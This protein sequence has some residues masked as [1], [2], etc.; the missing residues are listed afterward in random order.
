MLAIHRSKST[1]NSKNNRPLAPNV[2]PATIHHSGP[3]KVSKRYWSPASASADGTRTS[4]FRGRRL[5]GRTVKLPAGYEGVLLQKT[6]EVVRQEGSR[7]R[8]PEEDMAEEEEDGAV[9]GGE[10]PEVR[11]METRGTF[12]EVTVWGHEMAPEDGDEYVKGIR[13]WIGFAE[14]VSLVALLVT[15]QTPRL[16][17]TDTWSAFSQP[18]SDRGS[19]IMRPKPTQK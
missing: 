18:Q 10:E 13:E 14:A 15:W 2:L 1:T 12:D 4:H 9:G 7:P 6:G 3:I 16:T 5:K 11:V 17:V 8:V 19:Q